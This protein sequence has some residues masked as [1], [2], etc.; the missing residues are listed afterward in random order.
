MYVLMLYDSRFC[1]MNS[2][3]NGISA[4]VIE[5]KSMVFYYSFH[6]CIAFLFVFFGS[7][8][9]E[10][11]LNSPIWKEIFFIIPCHSFFTC[12]PWV[13]FKRLNGVSVCVIEL[14]KYDFSLLPPFMCIA[15][16]WV[17]V[18]LSIFGEKNYM[19][20][21]GKKILPY[22]FVIHFLVVC[23]ERCWKGDKNRRTEVWG[24]YFKAI[25]KQFSWYLSLWARPKSKN[26]HII[27]I[28]DFLWFT[29]E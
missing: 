8:F 15:F 18:F 16:L 21:F 1:F 25:L 2:R 13:L 22:F 19:L 23:P 4:C 7:D 10:K 9:R 3:S 27:K 6:P 26:T 17:C 29:P 20:P 5:L 28:I 12:L 11:I 24:C 14:K